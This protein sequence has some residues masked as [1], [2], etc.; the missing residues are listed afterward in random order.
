VDEGQIRAAIE[1]ERLSLADFL[2]GLEPAEWAV[3]SLCPDWTV[4]EVVA[5][6]TL[7]TRT[8][9]FGMVAGMLRAR[10]DFHRMTATSARARAAAFPPAELIRQLRETAASTRR[11]PGSGPLTPLVD[12]LV[13]GQD[14][15]RP[16]ARP[17]SMPAEPATAALAFVADVA[18][19]GAPERLAGLT[20]IATDTGHTLGPGPEP[21]RGSTDD[22]LLVATGRPAG[23]AGLSGPGVARL[24]SRLAATPDRRTRPIHTEDRR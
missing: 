12:I 15:V 9:L 1:Y 11:M 5:H 10:G 23:L 17:R 8:S 24:S 4:R 20:L 16:L 18:F 22:L 7:P 19:Y 3:P 21:V 2:D 6:L 13:H 14:I